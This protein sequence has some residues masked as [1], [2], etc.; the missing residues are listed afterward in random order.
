M[1]VLDSYV[2][3]DDRLIKQAKQLRLEIV[4]MNPVDYIRQ[5]AI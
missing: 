2:P 3:Y 5:E 4:V 1:S